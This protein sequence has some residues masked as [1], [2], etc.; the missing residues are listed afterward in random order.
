MGMSTGGGG[1]GPS[2]LSEI[3]VTPLVDVMLALLLVFMVTTPILVEDISKRQVDIDLPTTNSKAVKQ[4]EMQTILRLT[5]T[6]GVELDTGHDE[7]ATPIA[8]CK[9]AKGDYGACLGR[10]TDQLKNNPNL[11][12]GQRLFIMADRQLPYG[13]VVDVMSRIKLAGISNLGM[14]TNPPGTPAAA[15][16][17]PG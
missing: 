16:G 1:R 12:P 13:F 15:P 2:A 5:G 6:L 3:N 11:K 17:G 9:D 4:S 10:L 8:D 14:V 7:G